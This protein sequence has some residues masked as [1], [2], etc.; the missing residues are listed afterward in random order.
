MSDIIE[1]CD[2]GLPSESITIISTRESL[3]RSPRRSVEKLERMP[4]TISMSP[5]RLLSSSAKMSRNSSPSSSPRRIIDDDEPESD[6]SNSPKTTPVCMS[7]I[8][9]IVRRVRNVRVSFTPETRVFA[10][11]ATETCV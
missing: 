5:R 10:Y 11:A 2:D 9:T 1:Y 6:R 4:S 8:G 3:P 7:D